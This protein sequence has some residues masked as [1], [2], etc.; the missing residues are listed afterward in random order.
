[1]AKWAV[2]L[3]FEL[4]VVWKLDVLEHIKHVLRS[5]PLHRVNSEHFLQDRNHLLRKVLGKGVDPSLNF[6][7]N[8]SFSV[9]HEREVASR[10]GVEDHSTAPHVNLTS[11]ILLALLEQLRRHVHEASACWF[12]HRFSIDSKAKVNQF[13]FL[14]LFV[15]NYVFKFDVSVDYL[16]RA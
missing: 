12:K 11:K 1:M 8:I 7:N 15:V 13:Y 14:W 3:L 4:L 10:Y 5:P 9:P 6:V 16:L 2:S